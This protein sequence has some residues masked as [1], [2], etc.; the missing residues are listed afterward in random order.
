MLCRLTLPAIAWYAERHH[1][2]VGQG[3]S[4]L[5]G[6]SAEA[7]TVGFGV[8]SDMRKQELERAWSR[9]LRGIRRCGTRTRVARKRATS[10]RGYAHYA[11]G[12][13]DLRDMFVASGR[14]KAPFDTS[15]RRALA[16]VLARQSTS[17]DPGRLDPAGLLLN[18]AP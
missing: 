12:A 4:D 11:G 9:F 17:P 18:L 16:A 10:T 13:S 1:A 6:S 7:A 15:G 5:C 14:V 3:L 8:L 2:D